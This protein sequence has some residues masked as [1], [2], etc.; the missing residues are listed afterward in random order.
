VNN[1][2]RG[3]SAEAVYGVEEVNCDESTNNL[4]GVNGCDSVKSSVGA[5]IDETVNNDECWK[6]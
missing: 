2:E 5:K 1:D 4:E 6:I 3:K